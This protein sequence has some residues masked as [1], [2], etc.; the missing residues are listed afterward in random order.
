[1]QPKEIRSED[2]NFKFY[3]LCMYVCAAGE[4]LQWALGQSEKIK[5]RYNEMMINSGIDFDDDDAGSPI[6][7]GD[8]LV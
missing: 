8:D 7:G 2:Y 6:I 3:V 4:R 5:P 1:M